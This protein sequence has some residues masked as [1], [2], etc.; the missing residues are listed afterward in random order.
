MN[1]RQSVLGEVAIRS[2]TN[3]TAVD[4]SGLLRR[5]LLF[6]TVVVKSVRLKELPFL[7]RGLG[8]DGFRHLLNS[9]TYPS[10]F[11]KG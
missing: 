6:D 7:V 4:I 8:K 5:L 1:V 9:G 3:V 10:L 11:E 2:G